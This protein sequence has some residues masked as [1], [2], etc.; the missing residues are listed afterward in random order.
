M[1]ECPSQSLNWQDSNA[2]TDPQDFKVPAR[3]RPPRHRQASASIPG[4]PRAAP[5]RARRDAQRQHVCVPDLEIVASG[6]ARLTAARD[7]M[8]M[9]GR[10][11]LRSASASF[12]EDADTPDHTHATLQRQAVRLDPIYCPLLLGAKGCRMSGYP[13]RW[14][15]WDCHPTK[16]ESDQHHTLHNRLS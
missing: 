3:A 1:G 4:S 12:C 13:V 10:V 11:W 9:F 5:G 7:Q 16:S 8:H 14:H 6:A 15:S 2:R